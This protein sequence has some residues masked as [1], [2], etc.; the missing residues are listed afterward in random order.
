MSQS[1]G[2]PMLTGY[3]SHQIG[4]DVDIWFTPI[5]DH[6][7]SQEEREF[8]SALNVVAEDRL[9]VDPKVWTH[10]HTEVVRFAAEDPVV[11]RIFVN[12]AIRRRCAARRDRIALGC[13]RCGRGGDMMITFMSASAARRAAQMQTAN[14]A[15][16][17]WGLRA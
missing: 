6:E 10:A 5:P 9:D 3:C 11:S 13:R 14:A 1:R 4:L 7:L 8:N 17:G 2:G 12:A 16:Y 15:E